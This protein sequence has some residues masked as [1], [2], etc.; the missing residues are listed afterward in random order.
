MGPLNHDYKSKWVWL[1]QLSNLKL[2]EFDQ[3]V[4]N[5]GLTKLKIKTIFKSDYFDL[6]F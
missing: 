3:G 4:K 5:F 2:F 6:D 1:C